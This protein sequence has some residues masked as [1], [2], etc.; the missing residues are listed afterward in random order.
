MQKAQGPTVQ[1]FGV[2]NSQESRAAERFF[3]ERRVQVHYVDLKVKPMAPGELKRFVEKFGLWGLIDRESKEFEAAGLKYLRV[4]DTDLLA[5]IEKEPKLLKLPFVRGANRV[6]IGKDE[7][8]W[9]LMVE[10]QK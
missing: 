5:K 10:L 4:G 2:K 3:K 7:E 8:T 1:I 6:A 9:K